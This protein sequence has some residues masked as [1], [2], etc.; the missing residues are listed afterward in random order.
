MDRF[1]IPE[2]PDRY[3]DVPFSFSR[4]Y[5]AGIDQLKKS[6]KPCA[7]ILDADPVLIRVPGA[8]E[9]TAHYAADGT[10]LQEAPDAPA[11]APGA[12]PEDGRLYTEIGSAHIEAFLKK[13]TRDYLYVFPDGAR[14]RNQGR[15]LAPLPS[16]LRWSWYQYTAASVLCLEDPMFYT[17]SE[18]KLGWFYG[19]ETEDYAEYCA[20]L[21]RHIAGLLDIPLSHVILYGPSGGGHAAINMSAFIPGC[22]AVTVNGQYDLT[23]HDYWLEGFFP[24]ITGLSAPGP[25]GLPWNRSAEII[26]EHPENHYLLI[27]NMLSGQDFDKQLHRLCEKLDIVPQYGLKTFGHLTVW[28]TSAQGVPEPHNVWENEL[29][30]RM[31]DTLL[32]NLM[33]GCSAQE[34]CQYCEIINHYWKERYDFRAK[35]RRLEES[36]DSLRKSIPVIR[37]TRLSGL[38]RRIAQ[39]LEALAGTKKQ[40]ER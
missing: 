21:V 26:R 14:T 28:L 22:M 34:I 3:R 16:F 18:I 17:F 12:V 11:L 27:C 38:L 1:V 40:P 32:P 25:E 2:Y 36:V 30:F 23:L 10:P 19:T 5:Q 39:K 8:P 13:G 33:N 29:Q 6:W 35:I 31:I 4:D 9:S 7:E 24:S 37:P 15:D 20:M